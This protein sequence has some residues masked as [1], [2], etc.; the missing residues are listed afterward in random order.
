M[1]TVS[2][3][4]CCLFVS[5]EELKYSSCT[6]H[7]RT[8][9]FINGCN[10]LPAPWRLLQGLVVTSASAAAT[11]PLKSLNYHISR[12]CKYYV[13]MICRVHKTLY[14]ELE[15]HRWCILQCIC[16]TILGL[17]NGCIEMEIMSFNVVIA[18]WLL[19]HTL[20]YSI[21]ELASIYCKWN[22]PTKLTQLLF[23]VHY[24]KSFQN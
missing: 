7:P 19:L 24:I 5:C 20:G 1:R 22:K 6:T 10:Q 17:R 15:I 18:S 12:N 11:L 9:S 16:N 21:I 13:F 23:I 8:H 3:C 2:F 4:F 14:C